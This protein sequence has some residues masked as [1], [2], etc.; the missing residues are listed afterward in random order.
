[1]LIIDRCE[2]D[3]RT[4]SP[5]DVP[6]TSWPPVASNKHRSM[7]T[8]WARTTLMPAPPDTKAVATELLGE[9][10]DMLQLVKVELMTDT[11]VAQ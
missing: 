8:F 9:A 1:M 11:E 5:V 3:A 7:D 6:L 10:S 2:F 4:S